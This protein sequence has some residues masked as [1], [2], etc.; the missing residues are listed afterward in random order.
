MVVERED[1]EAWNQWVAS[2]SIETE[3]DRARAIKA[4]LNGL[5]RIGD[6]RASKVCV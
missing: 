3:K 6:L 4:R 1:C 5:L 2:I